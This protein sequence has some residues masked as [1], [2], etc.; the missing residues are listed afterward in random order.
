VKE[1]DAH[2]FDSD[3]L[4]L[5]SSDGRLISLLVVTDALHLD[6]GTLLVG[7]D[8]ERAPPW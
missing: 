2:L 7:G 8:G 3:R 4:L 5:F 6:D 1:H